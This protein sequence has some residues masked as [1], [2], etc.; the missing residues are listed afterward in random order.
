LQAGFQYENERGSE[1]G[2]SY[3]PPVERNNYDYRAAVHGD[4]RNRLFYTL[5]GDLEHYSLFGVQTTPRAAASFYALRPRKGAFSGTRILFNFGDAVREPSLTDQF[6][7]LYNF[8]EMNGGQDTIQALGIT[9]IAAPT[10]RMY[11]GGVEQSFFT[12][13]LIFKASFFHNEFGKQIEYV[14]VDLIPELLPNLTPEQQKALQQQLLQDGAYELTLNTQAYRAMG[15]E[16][17]L[18]SGI[19]KYLFLRGGYTY[20]DAVI[21]KSY[22]NDD[23]ALLGPLPEFDGIPIG[24]Y[25]PLVGARP[26]RRA[27]NTGF[28]TASFSRNRLNVLFN[29]AFVSRSDDSTFLAG[30][31]VNFGNSLLLPNRNLDPG[32]A[33]LDVA[34]SMR[35]LDWLGVY[36]QAENLTDNQHIAPI[37]YVSLPFNARVGLKLQWGREKPN[38]APSGHR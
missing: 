17:T 29:S 21:Q 37:G 9:P 6:Y 22:T 7:S 20:L 5:G 19:G 18:E 10:A 13:H 26:F 12:Q 33:K 35:I 11:E 32:Y 38:V 36:A 30:Y 8:L 23:E 25:S 24:P 4:F 16:A 2:S 34:G 14:G 31:D 3:Y 27:P 1:P 15:V 28:F